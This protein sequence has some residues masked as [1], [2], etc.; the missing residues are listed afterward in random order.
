MTYLETTFYGNTLQAWAIALSI[1]VIAFLVL[2]VAAS[3]LVGRIARLAKR[4]R[5]DWDDVITAG[6]QRTK[7]IIL[8]VFAAFF[9]AAPLTLPS[10]VKSA[11]TS[12]A[13]IALFVQA[14][15][16]VVGGISRW[17]ELYRERRMANDAAAVMSVGAV[18]LMIRVG[19]WSLVVLLS[20]GNMGIDVTALVAGLG[21]GGVAIALASQ[22]ILGDLFASLSIVLDKPFVLG[23]FLIVDDHLG[24]VED[25]GLKTT[26]V[27]SL[28][29][30]QLVFSNADLLNSRI[31]NYGR[32]FERRVV[33]KIGVTYQTSREKVEK[34]PVI[35]REAVESLGEQVRFDRAHFQAYGD[36]AL[37]FETVYYVLGPDYNLY[38][39]CQ[40]AIN[41]WIHERFEAEEIEFAYPT[42][43][44]FLVK[45]GGPEVTSELKGGG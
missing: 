3:F 29:G 31:R 34:I 9:G 41:L 24:S 38:M 21:I 22:S 39:D 4:T 5:T 37:T 23:D 6:L 25:I 15:F 1:T 26:R 35:L 14:G 43:T 8:L 16:W 17:M 2:R 40:Q 33:F 18:S 19:V 30:E 42:Q 27:R 36:F 44:L 11:L 13:A 10:G 32:M 20:L 45:G 7:G 12:L 28:S